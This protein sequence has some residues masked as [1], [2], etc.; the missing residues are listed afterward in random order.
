MS[1][2]V[3]CFRCEYY[4]EIPAY[5]L[6]ANIR[7][8]FDV[9]SRCLV[10][11]GR[12]HFI[13]KESY[14]DIFSINVLKLN[15]YLSSY[16]VENENIDFIDFVSFILQAS[17]YK[18]MYV[19]ILREGGF[20]SENESRN[21]LETTENEP[22]ESTNHTNSPA[23]VQNDTEKCT[24]CLEKYENEENVVK[25]RCNHVFHKTCLSKWEEN[26]NNTCP[27]CRIRY[28]FKRDT[29]LVILSKR[30]GVILYD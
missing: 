11:N 5:P 18:R 6:E 20:L 26:N 12:C 1:C 23:E 17:V 21:D 16:E 22:N 9:P 27:V 25:I 3:F 10:C 8:V 14:E 24:I 19:N 29:L 28:V 30:I 2:L 13:W 7:L 15:N 4:N